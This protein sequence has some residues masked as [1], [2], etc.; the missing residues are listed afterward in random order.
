MAESHPNS[1]GPSKRPYNTIIPGMCT[2]DEGQLFCAFGVMGGFMQPQGQLQVRLIQHS[3]VFDA[4]S[5]CTG[6]DRS[7]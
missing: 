6:S 3:T 5:S 4:I 1:I 2:D 7:D